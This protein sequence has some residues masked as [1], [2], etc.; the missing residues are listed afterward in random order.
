MAAA[1]FAPEEPKV[2]DSFREVLDERPSYVAIV[3]NAPI[4]YLDRP[5]MGTRSCDRDARALLGRRALTIRDAPSR[6]T[7]M[8]EVPWNESHLDAV[9]IT[10]LPRY[11][12]VAAEMSPFRQRVVYSGNP[13]LS[14]YELNDRTPLRW[15]KKRV[16][17]EEER[18]AI[19]M[20]KIPGINRI[21]DD[22]DDIAPISHRLDSAAL[23]WTS[24]RVFGHAAKRLPI[25]GEWDSEGMRTEMVR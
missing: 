24:R 1:T 13:E 22:A 19:L 9:T 7:L 10:L 11:M 15:S 12:E 6:A 2:F 14:F 23:M 20:A 18:R 4:G 25:D 5:G 17:G 21:I 16:E 8:G 3:V